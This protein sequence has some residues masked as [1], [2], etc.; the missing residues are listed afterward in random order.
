MQTQSAGEESVP[1]APL[2]DHTALDAETTGEE[3]DRLC[4][5][6]V[7][8]AFAAVCVNPVW[9]ERASRRLQ[10]TGV[11]VATVAG[12]PLGASTPEAKASEAERSLADGAR[13]IDMVARIGAAREGRWGDLGSDVRAVREAVGGDA[14]LKVILE[15][16]VLTPRQAL[17]AGAVAREAGADFLKTSTGFHEA[18]GATPGA[19]AALRVAAGPEVG[20]KAAGGIRSCADAQA[21]IDA[22]AT[23]IGSSSGVELAGCRVEEPE[24]LFSYLAPEGLGG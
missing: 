5:E 9:V 10:G 7:E 1:L 12:F 8:H 2:I 20:V 24:P 11:P 23:R 22:G 14:L 18:G 13:E 17:K 16:A 3:V 15:T 4:R 19:V 6:A 21:V